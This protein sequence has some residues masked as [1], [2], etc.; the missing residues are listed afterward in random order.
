MPSFAVEADSRARRTESDTT[1]VLWP[2]HVAT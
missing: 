1:L 2:R